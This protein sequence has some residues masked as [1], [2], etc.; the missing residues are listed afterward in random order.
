[1]AEKN[2]GKTACSRL[3]IWCGVLTIVT[4]IFTPTGHIV[5]LYLSVGLSP[6]L[7]RAFHHLSIIIMRAA[8]DESA[9]GSSKELSRL[10]SSSELELQSVLELQLRGRLRQSDNYGPAWGV[11]PKL[12][13]VL[14]FTKLSHCGGIVQKFCEWIKHGTPGFVHGSIKSCINLI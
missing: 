5:R 7:S 3:A 13:T 9:K 8:G 14:R 10:K 1:M 4:Y 12:G 2:D 11:T 6:S